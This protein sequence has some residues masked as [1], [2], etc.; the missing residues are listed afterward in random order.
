[1][2]FQFIDS[3]ILKTVEQVQP[4]THD[5]YHTIRITPLVINALGGGHTD[6]STH[7]DA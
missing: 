6:T 4:I 3:N 2:P 7:T 5:L 1:M